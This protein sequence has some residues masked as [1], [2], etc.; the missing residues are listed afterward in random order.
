MVDYKDFGYSSNA[1]SS[2]VSADADDRG[3]G[4]MGSDAE[5]RLFERKQGRYER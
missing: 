4:R 1:Q 3:H 2:F 5:G